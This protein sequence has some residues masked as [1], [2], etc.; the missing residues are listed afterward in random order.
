MYEF[1]VVIYVLV[2]INEANKNNISITYRSNL[3]LKYAQ[4]DLNLRPAD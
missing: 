4:Q 1:I 2:T 3:K